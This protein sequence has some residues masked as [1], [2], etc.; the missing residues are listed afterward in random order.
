M[1]ITFKKI[2]GI[3]L[4]MVLAL[5]VSLP[6][7]AFEFDK[8][9]NLTIHNNGDFEIIDA[10]DKDRIKTVTFE[11]SVTSIDGYAFCDCKNLTSVTIGKNV[12]EINQYAF[13]DCKKLKEVTIPS[14]VE[15]IGQY[16]FKGCTGLTSVTIDDNAQAHI[17]R[18]AFAGCTKLTS[19]TIP[20]GV[21]SI[22]TEVFQGCNNLTSVTIGENVEMIGQYAFSGCSKLTSIDVDEE[23]QYY[24]S[25]DGVLF[26]KDETR[27]IKYPDGKTEAN[28]TI[29]NS[30]TVIDKGAFDKHT[31]INRK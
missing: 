11:D 9:G 17:D 24:K 12:K 19:I 4:S 6:A 7:Y 5:S 25:I 30:V 8:S 18:Q 21:T 1:K 15:K 29:P 13:Q 28:Y 26:S 10:L 2:M 31:K 20:D 3:C 22:S 14:K 27:L 23:N 16:A